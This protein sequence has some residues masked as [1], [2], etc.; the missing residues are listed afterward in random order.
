MIG[1]DIES[2]HRI[3]SLLSKKPKIIRK[4]F[5]DYEWEYSHSKAKAAQTLT[6]IWCAKEAVIKALTN[7]SVIEITEIEI[8]HSSSGA[9]YVVFLPDQSL[10]KEYAIHISIS[11]SVEY[12]TAIAAVHLTR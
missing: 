9:P 4:F 10:I 5:T 3:E 11:H 6:G 12:A 7:I 2:I 1:I 8:R